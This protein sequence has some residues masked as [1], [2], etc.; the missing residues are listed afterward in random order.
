[1]NPL[2]LEAGNETRPTAACRA[3][4]LG[5]RGDGSRSGQRAVRDRVPNQPIDSKMMAPRIEKI[6]P[7]GE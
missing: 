7:E 3:V 6:Q 1:M 4:G 5:A 2:G